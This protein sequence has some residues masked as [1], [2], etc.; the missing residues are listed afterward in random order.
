MSAIT[1]QAISIDTNN[2]GPVINKN[3]YGQFAEHLGR[4]IYEGIW[5]GPES[6]IPNTRGWRNDVVEALKEL[7]VPVVRWPGGC[8]ADE[9]HWRN[10]IGPRDQRPV[11]V[12]T[13]WGGVE[14]NNAVGTHEFFDLVELLGAEAYVN[15]NMGTG[16]PQEMAEW[17]EYMTS[18]S[19]S[20]LAELRHKNG[21]DEPYRVHHFGIGNETWGAGGHMSPE[22]YT[23]LYKHW[24]TVLR[25]P[26]DV[27]TKYVASGGHGAEAK[28]ITRWTEY[29]TANIEPNFLLGF[30][31][32]SFHYYTH[33]RGNIFEA[34]GDATQFPEAEWISTLHETLKI[35]EHID[36]NKAIMDRNDPENKIGF[37][38]DEWGTWYDVAEGTNP[39]FLYQQNS[40]RD[41]VVAA[42]NFN[43]FHSY[44]DRVQMTNIAQ[45]VNVLQAMILTDEDKMILTPTYY[46]YKMYVPFQEATS[47]PLEL[48]NVTQYQL[49]EHAIPAV[50]ASAARGNDGKVYL[51]L[52]NTHP[53]QVE[54]VD[55]KLTGREV[56]GV[57]GEVLT[58][59]TMDA[60]N[61]FDKPQAITPEAYSATAKS[62]ELVLEIP[63]KAIVVVAVE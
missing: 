16:T 25:T 27:P 7:H 19:K 24:S 28:D 18:D 32:V 63:A 56:K 15:G 14:E 2:P 48:S 33:P 49:G 50:S 38:I 34:K 30:D 57:N 43:I 62:G 23:S 55:V 39:G 51:A 22:Y 31:A 10:G 1:S 44:A 26:W 11:T 42:L 52:V 58:A 45:M 60:H 37:Y 21:R 5:V 59:N 3:I 61:T 8:F 9:Y 12:N 35:A 41:A 40:L 13:L 6:S 54:T 17:L 4:G 29:L 20:D 46:A 47:L 53:H 36:A